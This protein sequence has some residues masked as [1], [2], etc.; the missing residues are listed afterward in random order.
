MDCPLTSVADA[1]VVNLNADFMSLGRGDVD[2]LD[3]QWLARFPCH[4]CF[5][6]DCLYSKIGPDQ[7]GPLA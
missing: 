1:S 3:A 7:Y 4:G 5:A 6:S 2:V